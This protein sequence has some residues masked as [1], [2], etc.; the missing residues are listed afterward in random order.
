M[1]RKTKVMV[2]GVWNNSSMPWPKAPSQPPHTGFFTMRNQQSGHKQ[3]I[4]V[5]HKPQVSKVCKKL[6]R[7]SK[8]KLKPFLTKLP[9]VCKRAPK[10]NKYWQTN[11]SQV[12]LSSSADTFCIS[13][14]WCL[15]NQERTWSQSAFACSHFQLIAA[16]RETESEKPCQRVSNADWKVFANPESFCNMLITGWRIPG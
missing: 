8:A 3:Q 1:M 4:T 5:T 13:P 16:D 15:Y 14:R 10:A 2:E 7:Q 9:L 6:A 12:E 11:R